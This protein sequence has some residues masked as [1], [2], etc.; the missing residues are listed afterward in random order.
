[1]SAPTLTLRVVV[2]LGVVGLGS[3]ACASSS[4]QPPSFVAQHYGNI[5][6]SNCGQDPDDNTLIDASGTI[7]NS[8][9][10]PYEYSFFVSVNDGNNT[11]A[12][13]ALTYPVE[14]GRVLPW[15]TKFN[16]VGPLGGGYTCS[17]HNITGA[18]SQP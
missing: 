12:G 9:Q 5:T 10:V 16:I 4:P 13:G 2:L 7:K 3:G 8:L 15:S 6:L 1:M 18:P 17:L 11:V 14:P